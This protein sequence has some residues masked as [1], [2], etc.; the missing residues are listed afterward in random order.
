MWVVT[1]AMRNLQGM[2]VYFK[3]CLYQICTLKHFVKFEKK[4]YVI[5]PVFWN[6]HGV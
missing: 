5:N 2:V 1:Y 6:Q 4:I 3:A